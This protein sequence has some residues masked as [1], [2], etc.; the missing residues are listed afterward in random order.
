MSVLGTVKLLAYSNVFVEGIAVVAPSLGGAGVGL[1]GPTDQGKLRGEVE[2]SLLFGLGYGYSLRAE[3]SVRF[4]NEYFAAG[5]KLGLR[6][7]F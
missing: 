5:G 4:G 3:S 1:A 7:A 2:G 6:K